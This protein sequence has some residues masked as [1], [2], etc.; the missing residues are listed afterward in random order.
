MM[1]LSRYWRKRDYH[2][3]YD[4]LKTEEYEYTID[5]LDKDFAKVSSIEKFCY[6]IYLLSKDYSVNNTLLLCDF[7]MYTDTFFYDVHSV[8][9]MFIRRALDLF[10]KDKTLLEWVVSTY[11][12]HPDS[13]FEQT[14]INAFKEQLLSYRFF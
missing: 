14:E 9:Q 3:I 12:S 11:E 8:I 6:L 2:S 10:P 5:N 7:L 4:I 13:P 1:D